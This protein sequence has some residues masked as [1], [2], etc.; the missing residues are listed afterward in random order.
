MKKCLQRVLMIW[1]VVIMSGCAY[2][3]TKPSLEQ[4]SGPVKEVDAE[5]PDDPVFGLGL[6][7]TKFIDQGRYQI[8]LAKMPGELMNEMLAYTYAWHHGVAYSSK[9]QKSY[10]VQAVYAGK[11]GGYLKDL[12]CGRYLQV[13]IE[14]LETFDDSIHVIIGNQRAD[15]FYDL[16]GNRVAF[17]KED[18][19]K[20]AWNKVAT[21]GVSNADMEPFFYVN[22]DLREM[23][24]RT[25]AWQSTGR[26]LIKDVSTDKEWY[27]ITPY[28]AETGGSDIVKE[29]ARLNPNYSLADKARTASNGFVLTTDP[30]SIGISAA[31][32]AIQI[33]FIKE[34]KATSFDMASMAERLDKESNGCSENRIYIAVPPEMAQQ[35]HSK[36]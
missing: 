17:T 8:V 1:L 34:S 11:T 28:K 23:K 6:I 5:K 10:P 18:Y 4:L 32:A 31:V 16:R 2:N 25:T 36:K 12:P 30:V 20:G 21:L 26:Y 13:Y 9:T 3:T 33:P 14:G 27:I 7:E 22:E 19:L 24:M 29:V 15:Q 35:I